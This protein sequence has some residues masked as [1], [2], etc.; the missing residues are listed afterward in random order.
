[1][2]TVLSVAYPFAPVSPATAGGSEQVLL[3]IDRA[4]IQAGHTSLVIATADSEVYGELVPIP[5]FE[6]GD[7]SAHT[8]M[9]RTIAQ[10]LSRHR[11]DVIHLHGLDFANYIPEGPVPVLGTLHLPP[12]WYSASVFGDARV[13]IHC[14]SDAQQQRCPPSSNLLPPIPN[15]VNADFYKPARRK[16]NYAVVLARICPEKGLHYAIDAARAAG[17]PLV[18]AGQLFHYAAHEEYFRTEI[19]PRNP[20]FIGQAGPE[21]KRR[22]L[23][24][25]RC[26]LVPSTAPET[27]SLVAME[28]QSCG[29]PVVAFAAG[30][31]PS[32][33]KNGETGFVVRDTAGMAD[34]IRK[35]VHL[36]P[37]R[38]REH[39]V[40]NFPASKTT[41]AYI[42]TYRRLS[43]EWEDLFN[44]CPDAPP[45]L[46]PAWQD[47]WWTSF[48][49]GD[50]ITLRVRRAGE[51][52]AFATFYSYKQR[53][54]FA[55]NGISDHLG[56]LAADADAARELVD[57]LRR[58]P[59][60]LQEIAEGSP[61]L[62]M[63]HEQ[64][65]VSPVADLQQPVPSKLRRH[66]GQQRKYLGNHRFNTVC[67]PSLVETLV[68]LHTRV[69]HSRGDRGMLYEENAAFHRLCA[70]R[71]AQAG[72][73][74]IHTLSAGEQVIGILYGMATRERMHFYLSGFDPAY[75][76]FS[77]GSL[78]IEYAM[79]YARKS[80][81]RWFD[82]LR[83]AEAYKY[84]WGA[85]D[86]PQFRIVS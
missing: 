85:A 56:I 66:L 75:E 60:D 43:T 1:M 36:D 30:A 27:S 33:V 81:Q 38:C 22:L 68:D 64:C 83:G 44:R 21:R 45:F 17:M 67:D 24:G 15:G 9:R 57:Q 8:T 11:V 40:T 26:V 39:A 28:A 55:G 71:L 7:E 79:D 52:V 61:L 10:V 3:Q 13:A 80:G 6:P 14:V 70:P 42:A 2:L 63:P 20:K 4:L 31:L 12:E 34:A 41:A 59:L 77:P 62:S 50:R 35:S 86:R 65:S 32:I 53:L 23:A 5:R 18:V 37:R 82:F 76:R 47:P 51:L 46:H 72:L 16:R 48:G 58:R 73:L 69:W 19:V 25:A 49:S 78:L 54:V 74:R 84:R 29:T